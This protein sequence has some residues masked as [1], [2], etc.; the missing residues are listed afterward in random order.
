MSVPIKSSAILAPQRSVVRAAARR[1][2]VGILPLVLLA[3]TDLHAQLP[4]ARLH[5]V[6]PPGGQSGAAVDLTI[7]GLDLDEA[8]RLFFSHPNITASPKVSPQQPFDE[9][10]LP[11]PGEF[12]VTIAPDVP[13]GIYEVRAGG[14]FGTS[15]ARSFAVSRLPH[16]VEHGPNNSLDAAMPLEINSIVSGHTAADAYDVYQFSAKRGSRVL[17]HCETLRLDSQL[18]AVLRVM[19]GSGNQVASS[20]DLRR[21][22]PL[23]DLTVPA[24]ETYRVLVHDSTFRGG[25]S[26]FY[27]LS[28]ST[29][30]YIDFVLPPLGLPDTTGS[31]TLFGRNL[32]GAI[33]A[34]GVTGGVLVE[35]VPLQQLQVEIP[36]PTQPA[37][38]ESPLPNTFL[39]PADLGRTG[40]QYRL[41][42]LTE[43]SNP[44]FIA[45]S[46]APVIF[47]IEPNNARE[48]PQRLTNLPCEVIG[49]FDGR[50]DADWF[51]F[52]AEAGSPLALE[53]FSQ[54]LGLPTDPFLLV[55][56][57]VTDAEGND[58]SI[59]VVEV[60]DID[61][62]FSN[63]PF[64]APCRDAGC[65]FTPD[66]AGTFRVLV[67][68][69]NAESVADPRQVYALSIGPPKPEFE[70]LATFKML[71]DPDPNQA[72]MSA[73]ILRPGGTQLTIVQAYRRAG[74][75]GEI[76]ITAEDLPSGVVCPPAVI[77]AGQNQTILGFAAHESA[78]PVSRPL[79]II[80]TTTAKD[81]AIRRSAFY[82]TVVWDKHNVNEITHARIRRDVRLSVIDD[83]APLSIT[84]P[85]SSTLP[86]DAPRTLSRGEK[87]SIPVQVTRREGAKGVLTIETRGLPPGVTAATLSMDEKTSDAMLEITLEPTAPLGPLT[88][89]LAGKS[90]VAYR[91]SPQAAAAA[92]SEKV[93]FDTRI[94]Q[95]SEASQSA[96]AAKAEAEM[97][98]A[99]LAEGVDE[100][101][102][103]E[104]IAA[105]E[106]ANSA[107]VQAMEHLAAAQTH[108][109]VVDQR[110]IDLSAA[111]QPRDIE[112]FVQSLPVTFV[113]MPAEA[114]PAGP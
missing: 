106:A 25:D 29:D 41:N 34:S 42:T 101:V 91:R 75:D 31:F 54:R 49:Q 93:R 100:A 19:D 62:K 66:A 24:D 23:V 98:L 60:D 99:D 27:Q 52:E 3:T 103:A 4:E 111:A 64:D 22:E 88:F 68:D 90:K 39:V 7:H 79:K 21:N 35:G 83:T 55:Q 43:L 17:I 84:V 59:D 109:K 96:A 82:S 110:A 81:H 18:D 53:I 8:D 104:A 89:Y 114:P 87:L 10:P 16:V 108:S 28:V 12:T 5:G 65:V 105:A 15:T 94:V 78:A 63:P 71:A 48:Q 74:F 97:K 2:A 86:A 20:H 45:M 67:R 50:D 13:A 32:P 92:K 76:T 11:L 102:K 58:L 73:P 61:A 51:E 80:G 113:V 47:E 107:A 85:L 56:R 70:L 1:F 36:V 69:L 26:F 37:A 46:E 33:S 57:V 44:A 30:P 72:L 95:L 40:F 38:S 9:H 6:F 77:A 112:V 14:R